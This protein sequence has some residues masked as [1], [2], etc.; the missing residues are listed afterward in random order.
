[1]SES[2]FTSSLHEF[3]KLNVL[4]FCGIMGALSIVLEYVGSIRL[5]PYARI[6][7]TEI[8]NV[9]IDFFFGPVTGGI[10]AAVMD[11]VKYV[12]NPDGPFFPG[13]TLTAVTAAVIFGLFLYRRKLR[14]RNLI[15]AEILVKLI[16]NIGLNTVWSVMLYNKA[17]AVILPTRIVTNLIQLPIDTMVLYFVLKAVDRVLRPRL[18]E[19]M[20]GRR[21]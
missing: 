1:M 12:A 19:M 7:I 5:A 17:I 15:I 2:I 13:Y 3:R 8:P 11:I 18:Y 4:I 16:C 14:I 21:S 10:F 9:V 6:G 20:P